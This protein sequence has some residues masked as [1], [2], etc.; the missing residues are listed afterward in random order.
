M[1]KLV[2]VVLFFALLISFSSCSKDPMVLANK[3][4]KRVTNYYGAVLAKRGETKKAK[5]ELGA[6]IK[7]SS[8]FIGAAAVK[9][10]LEGLKE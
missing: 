5:A 10:I 2:Y 6:A 9:K 8:E 3:H 4:T 7:I 1:N